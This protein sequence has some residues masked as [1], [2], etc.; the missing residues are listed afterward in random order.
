MANSL[1][2]SF[3][4][5]RS[6]HKQVNKNSLRADA[7]AGLTNAAIVLPQGVAFAIIAGLPPQYGLY[8]AMITPIIA[9]LWGS[10]TIMIS[11]PTTAISAVM[12]AAI[13]ELAVPGTPLYVQ[14]ALALTIMVG[15]FQLIGGLCRLGG[16]ISF[17]SHSVMIGFTAAAAVLIAVSQL[18]GAFGVSVEGGGGV[19][20]R[21]MRLSGELVNFSPLA[22]GIALASFGTIVLSLKI[23]KKLPAYFLALVVGM[24][25]GKVF[26]ADE[27]GIAMFKDLPSITPAFGIPQISLHEIGLLLPSAISVAFIGLLTSISIGRTFAMRRG[28]RYDAN[29]EIVGQGLSNI[30]GG[31]LQSYAGSGSFTR[32][33]LNAEAGGRTPFSAI[34]AS[35]FLVGLLF[36]VSPLVSS[37]PVPAMAGIILNVAYRLIDFKEIKHIVSISQSEAAILF[38]TFFTGILVNLETSI[39]SGIF[40]SLIVFINR[41]AKT[42]VAAIAP[43]I[44]HGRRQMR[45]IEAYKLEQ[46]PQIN[47]LRIEGSLFFGSVEGIEQEFRRLETRFPDAKFKLLVLKGIGHI[48]MSSSD[49]IIDEIEKLRANA[50]DYHIVASYIGLTSALRRMHVTDV[51]GEENLHASKADAVAVLTEHVNHDICANCHIRNFHECASKPCPVG[52]MPTNVPAE[53]LDLPYEE[54]QAV[55]GLLGVKHYLKRVRG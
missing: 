43:A 10:S 15:L 36:M 54:P 45:D 26:N 48:D 53:I 38:V 3:S 44:Y 4:L 23:S 5:A 32:S 25:V 35:V 31:F 42:D 18:S 1:L 34:F 37:I 28:E 19:I 46:C 27:A 24:V 50:G 21:L 20:V 39:F 2:S 55:S 29:Q 51:L 52:S 17:I 11:G 9:A 7:I 33:A 47:I 6:W 13:A 30:V 12:F 40:V 8:T 41:S 22:L 49:L 16:L 14:F